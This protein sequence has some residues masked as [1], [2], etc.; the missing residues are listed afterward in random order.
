MIAA[1][2]ANWVILSAVFKFALE[3]WP[4]LKSWFTVSPEDAKAELDSILFKL[5]KAKEK[6]EELSDEEK[7]DVARDAA[8]GFHR[9]IKR[10]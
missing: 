10:L 2:K 4:Y 3:A 7:R 9:A 8:R 6:E 5:K 1:L